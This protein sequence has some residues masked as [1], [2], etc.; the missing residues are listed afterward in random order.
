VP[1]DHDLVT[2]GVPT[3]GRAASVERAIRSV[4]GQTHR[5]VEVVVA[6]DASLDETADVLRRLAAE[7]ERVRLIFH[8]AN[9][10]HARNF[11]CVFEAGGGPYFMWLSDDDWLD[12]DYVRR[13]LE[14]LRADTALVLVA[15]RARYEDHEL[16]ALERPTALSHRSAAGRVVRYFAQ[17]DLNGALYGIARR[18]D[19]ELTPFE[20]V[21]GG[22][23]LV[24]GGLA[25]QGGIATLDDV[26]V[27][28]S[29]RGI[30][31]D[32]KAFTEAAFGLGAGDHHLLIARIVAGRIAR[33][34]GSFAN[35]GRAPTRL[36]VAGISAVAIGMRFTLLDT[37]R[38]GLRRVG[39]LAVARRLIAPLRARRHR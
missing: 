14:V 31:S 39:M 6:D 24:V 37:A 4:L 35:L 15:G 18:A 12:P 21:I 9:I 27:H 8:E 22:D 34:Q 36:L 7:D 26:H 29:A 23:W 33:G 1:A 32:A 16:F 3:Y 13:C 5:A 20:E 17:V 28:R 10:G 25:A 38:R 30:S 19:L 2:V 11:R